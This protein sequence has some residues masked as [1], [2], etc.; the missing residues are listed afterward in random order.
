MYVSL[1]FV[2]HSSQVEGAGKAQSPTPQLSLDPAAESTDECV[3]CS[4]SREVVNNPILFCILKVISL[5][6][7]LLLKVCNLFL[8]YF[9]L[10][11]FNPC[12]HAVCCGFV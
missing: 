3:V 4:D 12:G 9:D 10:K 11:V 8:F 5:L 6:N 1:L 7:Q 2:C